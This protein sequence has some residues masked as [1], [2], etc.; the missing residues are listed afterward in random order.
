VSVAGARVGVAA[1]RD[2]TWDDVTLC[3]N[4]R[5]ITGLSLFVARDADFGAKLVSP[6]HEFAVGD[7]IT[8]S[9][10]RA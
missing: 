5:P 8:V 1:G 2:V 7:R 9:V 6:G 4:D 3:A 10:R